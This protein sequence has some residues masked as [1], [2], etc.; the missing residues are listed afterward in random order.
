MTFSEIE[1][2]RIKKH[3]NGFLAARRPP[4]HIRKQLDLAY[5]LEKQ[6]VLIYEVRPRWDN[7]EET[8]EEFVAKARFYKSRNEWRIYW[9]RADLKWHSYEPVPEVRLLEDFLRV[10][11]EDEYSCFFG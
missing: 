5:R 2:H 4:A 9:M 7:P 3:M 8:I 6:S 1:I 10:V 11:D